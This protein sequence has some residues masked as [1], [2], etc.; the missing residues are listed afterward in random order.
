VIAALVTAVTLFLVFGVVLPQVADYGQAWEAVAGMSGAWLLLLAAVTIANIAVYVWPYQAAIPGISF[1][2]A[3]VVRQTSYAIS[4]AVPGGGAFGLGVQYAMLAD[5]GFGGGAAAAAIGVT[6]VWNMLVT[7]ALPVL[8]LLW[9]VVAGDPE[10]WV[11]AAAGVG[12][13][14]LATVVAVFVLVFRS[15]GAARGLGG[16]ADRA[17]SR[18]GRV[19]GKDVTTDIAGVLLDFR[20]STAELIRRRVVSIT[21]SNTVQQLLQ[22]AVLLVALRAVEGDVSRAS[23]VEVFVAYAVGRLGGFIPLTPGGLGTVDALIIGILVAAGTGDPEALAAVLVWR[24]A[25]YFPQML[26]GG[27]TFLYWRRTSHTQDAGA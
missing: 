3:F 23:T 25:T 1:G 18:M 21:L 11:M 7:L 19:L 8:A 24:A 12:L 10:P 2:P 15:E 17:L 20:T 5:Y 9:F 27:G 26:I 13:L 6:S 22:F 4:N 16:F 14:A